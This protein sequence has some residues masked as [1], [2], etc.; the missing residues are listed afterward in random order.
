ML[1]IKILHLWYCAEQF[2]NWHMSIHSRWVTSPLPI[3]GHLMLFWN[4]YMQISKLEC[5][6]NKIKSYIYIYILII[7]INKWRSVCACAFCMFPVCLG[8]LQVFWFPPAFQ[9][10]ASRWQSGYAKIALNMNECVS[11]CKRNPIQ[12]AILP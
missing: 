6:N 7:M 10:H 4:I 2:G 11:V 8:F 3:G 12:G 1:R 9:K 5:L